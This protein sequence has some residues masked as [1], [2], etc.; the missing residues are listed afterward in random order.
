M[1]LQVVIPSI[2]VISTISE[3][4]VD[5]NAAFGDKIKAIFCVT[6][7]EARCVSLQVSYF[8]SNCIILDFFSSTLNIAKV[9][10]VHCHLYPNS[11]HD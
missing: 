3:I 9:D 11:L 5:P 2:L 4:E 10:N 7:D 1:V 8:C 6:D